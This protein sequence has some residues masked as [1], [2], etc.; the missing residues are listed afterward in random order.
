M[1][2]GIRDWGFDLS[3]IRMP[4]HIWHG[5]LDRNIPL[6]HADLLSHEIPEATIHRCPGEGHWMLV[7]HMA[8][9]LSVVATGL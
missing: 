2:I 3:E 7:D 8:E 4:I 6:V 1:A 5:D 9:V